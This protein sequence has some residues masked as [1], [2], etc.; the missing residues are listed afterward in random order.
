[1]LDLRGAGMPRTGLAAL[2]GGLRHQA[3]H[4]A[5]DRA[6]VIGDT[7]HKRSSSDRYE[8]RHQR[9]FDQVL[10]ELVCPQIEAGLKT[11]SV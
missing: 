6:D 5:E 8:S 2:R 3:G 1:L 10:P 9:V 11:L 7:G 4:F